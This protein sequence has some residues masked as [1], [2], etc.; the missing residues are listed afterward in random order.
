MVSRLMTTARAGGREALTIY[1]QLANRALIAAVPQ[2]Q[3][4][5]E[6]SWTSATNY[7]DGTREITFASSTDRHSNVVLIDPAFGEPY[8]ERI[9]FLGQ[10][11]ALEIP[12]P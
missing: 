2:A 10:R 6:E 11:L 4:F 3:P 8:V 12:I 7:T 5:D 1:R 9:E